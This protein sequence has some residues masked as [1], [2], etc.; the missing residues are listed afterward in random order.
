MKYDKI[1][2]FKCG[3]MTALVYRGNTYPD[4]RKIKVIDLDFVPTNMIWFHRMKVRRAEWIEYDYIIKL[5]VDMMSCIFEK[6]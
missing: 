2:A 3:T 6:I 1:E 5:H 4:F